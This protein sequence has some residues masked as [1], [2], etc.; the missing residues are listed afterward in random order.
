[1]SSSSHLEKMSLPTEK[2]GWGDS[3]VLLVGWD[4][5][6]GMQ[7]FGQ[8]RIYDSSVPAD[9]CISVV[10]V[11]SCEGQTGKFTETKPESTDP[12]VGGRTHLVQDRFGRQ[13]VVQGLQRDVL[14]Q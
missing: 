6:Q 13:N 9:T 2:R 5:H 7:G 4:G 12:V 10:Y 11:V 1:M 14:M 3:T 8:S